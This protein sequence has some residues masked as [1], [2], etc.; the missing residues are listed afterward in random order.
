MYATNPHL[1]SPYSLQWNAALEQA[2]GQ[3]QSLTLSYIASTGRQLYLPK[4]FLPYFL[5]NTNFSQNAYLTLTNNGASS[6]YNSFQVQFNR[7]LTRGMQALVS[8]TWSHSIDDATNKASV[9]EQLRSASDNDI[10]NN[11]ELALTYEIP[12]SYQNVFISA[13]LKHWSLD[14]RISA[15]SALPIDLIGYNAIGGG[16]GLQITYHPNVIGGIPIYV[17]DDIV[18]SGRRINTAAFETAYDAAGNPIEGDS[19]R[20][21]VR[22]YDAVEDN[23]AVQ[24]DFPIHERLS[25]LFRIEAFNVLNQPIYGAVYNDIEEVGLFGT[26]SGT[27]NNQLGVLNPLYQAGG[28]RSMQAALKLH[29]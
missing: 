28:P 8:Y 22:G 7:R 15:R 24:R 4:Q 5:G 3:N 17:H 9:F 23:V 21:S 20:N 11:F 2:I 10:R 6:S 19:G 12:R 26:A 18:P 25:L 27:L 16:S 1:S 29:F 14:S 13:L